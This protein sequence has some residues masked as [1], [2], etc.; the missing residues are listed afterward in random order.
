MEET[1]ATTLAVE[2]ET[3]S[4]WCQVGNRISIQTSHKYLIYC[5]KQVVEAR[6]ITLELISL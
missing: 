5:Y 4:L 6:A 3:I 1:Q 2:V